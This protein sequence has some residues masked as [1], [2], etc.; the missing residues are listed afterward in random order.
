VNH[1]D[2]T[3][4]DAAEQAR[5]ICDD[6]VGLLSLGFQA[7]NFAYPFGA[8]NSGVE[9]V[10]ASCGYNSARG[11][12]NIVSPGS[13][14]GCAYADTIPPNNIYHIKTPDSI[15]VDTTLDEMETYVTQ[16][17][18]N[19]GGWVPLVMHHVCDGCTTTSVSAATLSA[20]LDW[21]QPRSAM[22]TTVATIGDI[23]GGP[24]QP[25]VPGPPPTS[26]TLQNTSLDSVKSDGTPN[27]W[28]RAGYGTN[29]ARWTLTDQS[30]SGAYAQ[31]VDMTSLTYGDQ[32]LISAQD[33]GSCSPP[34]TPGKSYVVSAWY[35][36]NAPSRLVV[37]YRDTLGQWSWYAQG[38][39][40]PLTSTW[41]QTTWTTPPMP[42]DA[43]GI[44]IGFSL[45]AVGW[46][47]MDDFSMTQAP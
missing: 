6:R 3:T 41:T 1:V 2:L 28:R 39:Q 14:S 34:A 46:A 7:R 44:S 24:L 5:Q 16:A 40:L 47:L 21:L 35:M 43:T 11:V 32:K 22:G 20:F 26:L 42:A 38:P 31:R 29:T 27:C 19:G 45:R 33:L 4:V 18:Q 15:K 25:P 23:I 8:E 10:A 13:C 12:G 36:T 9:Q 37:Y 30:H 17:E